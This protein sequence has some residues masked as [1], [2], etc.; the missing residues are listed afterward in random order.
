M[1]LPVHHLQPRSERTGWI[2]RRAAYRSPCE[3]VERDGEA[4]SKS[5]DLDGSATIVDGRAEDRRHQQIREDEFGRQNDTRRGPRRWQWQAELSANDGLQWKDRAAEP[6]RRRRA[7]QLSHDVGQCEVQLDA[8]GDEEP[9][10]Y[11][12]I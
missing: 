10:G 7:K 11:R 9:A 8:A 5:A 1:P 4:D 12:G 6:G 2:H 3:N